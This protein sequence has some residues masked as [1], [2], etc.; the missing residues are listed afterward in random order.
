MAS[1]SA[2]RFAVPM[3][4][5]ANVGSHTLQTS[6]PVHKQ[7]VHK[8]REPT[9]APIACTETCWKHGTLSVK[10]KVSGDLRLL[11]TLISKALL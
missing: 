4:I 7:V 3:S 5:G 2:L 1:A 9:F 8:T 6:S 10:E 11:S